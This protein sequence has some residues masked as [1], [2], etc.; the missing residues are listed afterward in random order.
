MA[1]KQI[2]QR[3][4]GST[5][6]QNNPVLQVYADKD[7]FCPS[8]VQAPAPA[9]RIIHNWVNK[10]W[11]L[12]FNKRFPLPAYQWLLLYWFGLA[13]MSVREKKFSVLS[14]G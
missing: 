10:T 1:L 7:A 3:L 13:Y 6:Q 9:P 4:S 5:E 12:F 11:T 8:V 2:P 14:K